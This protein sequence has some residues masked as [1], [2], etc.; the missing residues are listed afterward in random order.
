MEDDFEEKI[1]PNLINETQARSRMEELI[2]YSIPV[3]GKGNA[4]ELC[5]IRENHIFF[6]AIVRYAILNDHNNSSLFSPDLTD[7]LLGAK[8]PSCTSEFI[9]RKAELK[10]AENCLLNIP[11]YL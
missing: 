10:E 8:C 3:I 5:S 2:T 9:G 6:T 7:V 1:I 4:D 11:F